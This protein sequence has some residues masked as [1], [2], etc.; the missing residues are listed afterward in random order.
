MGSRLTVGGAWLVPNVRGDVAA[1][2]ASGQTSVSDAYRYD[3]YGV[4]LA[5]LGTTTNPY[6]FQGR[7][8]ETTSGQYDFAARQYDPAIA[9]FTSLNTVLG[10]AA[11]PISLNRYLYAHANP[12]SMI[13]PDG[14][15]ACRYADDC[16]DIGDSGRL[17][18]LRKAVTSAEVEVNR[19][20]AGLA[21][22]QGHYD[23]ARAKALEPCAF[24]RYGADGDEL[25][26]GWR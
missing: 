7:L 6:R 13:D 15:A 22:V 24:A 3:P 21:W 10:R 5:S 8:L 25:C 2:L 20:R 4:L 17:D 12:T 9:A 14:H 23:R 18:A 26:A 16:A 11:N 1:L 19:T